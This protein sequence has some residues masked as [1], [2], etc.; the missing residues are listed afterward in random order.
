MI[1]TNI[2][3][4]FNGQVHIIFR[5]TRG[6]T[7]FSVRLG[8]GCDLPNRTVF[9]RVRWLQSRWYRRAFQARNGSTPSAKAT[10]DMLLFLT[11]WR[12]NLHP[13]PVAIISAIQTR[14]FSSYSSTEISTSVCASS[15]RSSPL[16][17][18]HSSFHHT[19]E[20]RLIAGRMVDLS[21]RTK[22]EKYLHAS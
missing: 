2:C 10:A 1:G 9:I 12:I 21:G 14:T 4:T 19:V 15:S 20:V 8:Y 11:T 3:I 18:H 13:R 16:R 5:N 17:L 6:M 7:N 22:E